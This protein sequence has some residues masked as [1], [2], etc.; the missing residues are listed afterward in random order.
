M[1]IALDET[2]LEKG[3]AGLESVRSWP[4]LL[5][6]N[7]EKLLR[8]GEDFDLF[9]I[10]PIRYARDQKVD[11]KDA[12]DLFLHATKAG[13]VSI[14]W[15]LL[16]PACGDVVQSFDSLTRVSDRL[17]CSLCSTDM[18]ANLDDYVEV[19]FTVLPAI[20]KIAPHDPAS[21]DIDE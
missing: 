13:L 20:R 18:K 7:F 6:D 1:T 21:L 9:R 2:S 15:N 11:E 3:L 16:C 17:H 5:I 12:I 4:S 8:E 10:N 14:E 19:S